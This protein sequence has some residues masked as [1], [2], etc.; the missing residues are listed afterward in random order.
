M[1]YEISV[2]IGW[3]NTLTILEVVKAQ[4]HLRKV[5]APVRR[6]AQAERCV[7]LPSH[8]FSVRWQSELDQTATQVRLELMESQQ[9]LSIHININAADP[10]AVTAGDDLRLLQQGGQ[11]PQAIQQQGHDEVAWGTLAQHFSL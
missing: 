3:I 9:G 4:A 10:F 11:A 5:A 1:N 2:A 7:H 6:S 8:A